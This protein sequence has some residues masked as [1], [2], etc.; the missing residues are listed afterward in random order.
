NRRI[1]LAG[2]PKGEPKDSDFRLEEVPMP[3]P[4]EDQV[5]LRTLYLSLDPYMRGRM[6]AGP[7]YA[8]PVEGNDVMEGGT[9][10]EV[11]ESNSPGLRPG[12]AVLAYTG[13]QEYAVAKAAQL[14]KLDLAL[15]PV[16]TALGVLGMPGMT[17]YTGLLNIGEP[18]EG[19]TVVVAAA[20]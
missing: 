20:A 6:N 7:S 19:E 2:R 9:V 15:A 12:D 11:I 4:G 16:S 10:C 18:K 3:S 1:V 17:A 13:W 14:H 8:A 5:L